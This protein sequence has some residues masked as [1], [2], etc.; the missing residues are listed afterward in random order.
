MTLQLIMADLR[1]FYDTGILCCKLRKKTGM[2]TDGRPTSKI[3]EHVYDL[4]AATPF[5]IMTFFVSIV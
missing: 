2:L 1:P 3:Y 4:P 5:L